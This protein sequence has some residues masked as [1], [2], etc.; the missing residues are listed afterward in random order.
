MTVNIKRKFLIWMNSFTYCLKQNW[1][2]VLVS[3]LF[4]MAGILLAILEPRF[5]DEIFVK[6]YGK[7]I[8]L[9]FVQISTPSSIFAYELFPILIMSALVFAA[10]C[11]KGLII[12]SECVFLLICYFKTLSVIYLFVFGGILGKLLA[13]FL[14]IP[15]FVTFLVWGIILKTFWIKNRQIMC[16]GAGKQTKRLL[17]ELLFIFATYAIVLIGE[18]LLYSIILGF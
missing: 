18:I 12:L 16:C 9:I 6:I 7:K 11:L 14:V 4:G 15:F 8:Y 1:P 13:I 3:V 17:S 10:C 5:G 2:L